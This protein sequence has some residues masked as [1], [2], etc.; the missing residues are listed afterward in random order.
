MN[1]TKTSFGQAVV[2][3]ALVL[4]AA[5]VT[6]RV[7]SI[8]VQGGRGTIDKSIGLKAI[9]PKQDDPIKVMIPV[10]LPLFVLSGIALIMAIG[11][12]QDDP[13]AIGPKQDD[14]IKIFDP[15]NDPRALV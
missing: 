15:N 5:G 4:V 14:P 1:N 7:N 8:I 6:K 2:N 3:V 10:L 12:K 13:K 9:G 11:P